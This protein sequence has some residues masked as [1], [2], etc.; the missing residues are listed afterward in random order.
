MLNARKILLLL[1]KGYYDMAVTGVVRA[2]SRRA[3]CGS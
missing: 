3:V 2:S 1:L